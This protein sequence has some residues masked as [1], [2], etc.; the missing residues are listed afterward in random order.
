MW[1]FGETN[2]NEHHSKQIINVMQKQ[3]DYIFLIIIVM[4]VVTIVY[5]LY[6]AG[7]YCHKRT[8]EVARRNNNIEI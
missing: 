1:P 6:K 8:V 3:N 7:M 2:H 4:I 5:V